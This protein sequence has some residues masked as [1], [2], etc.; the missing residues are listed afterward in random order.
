MLHIP[1]KKSLIT[2]YL[3]PVVARI[4]NSPLV[5]VGVRRVCRIRILCRL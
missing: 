1:L 3:A 5:F 2:P 4:R